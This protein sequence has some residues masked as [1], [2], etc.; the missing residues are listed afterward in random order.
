MSIAGKSSQQFFD[1]SAVAGDCPPAGFRSRS[2]LRTEQS[3]VHPV[4][5]RRQKDFHLGL[6]Q[7]EERID[8]GML[9]PESRRWVRIGVPERQKMTRE[10]FRNEEVALLLYGSDPLLVV[11][12]HFDQCQTLI[13]LGCSLEE[14][15]PFHQRQTLMIPRE[16][17]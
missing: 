15:P 7:T 13:G 2:N 10:S 1:G 8:I 4:G 12:D 6:I 14:T 16:G 3:L 17:S 9:G 11:V 5:P